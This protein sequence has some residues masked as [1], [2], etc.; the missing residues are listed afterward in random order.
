MKKK[1]ALTIDRLPVLFLAMSDDLAAFRDRALL[2]LGYAGAFRRSELVALDVP[3]L[4]FFEQG[5]LRVDRAGQ[6]RSP[7]SRPRVYVRGC[8]PNGESCV[9]SRRLSAG[10]PLSVAMGRSSGRSICADGSR[11]IVFD[12]SDVA[13][14]LRRRA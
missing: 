12:P 8:R 11:K 4:R 13:R 7:E 10:S 9:R 14:I 5:L 1:D 2:L 6:E 3:D